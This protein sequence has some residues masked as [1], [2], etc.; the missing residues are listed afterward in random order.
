MTKV[1]EWFVVV[2]I[3]QLIQPRKWLCGNFGGQSFCWS[4]TRKNRS[5]SGSKPVRIGTVPLQSQ[6][7]ATCIASLIWPGPSTMPPPTDT[8]P[9]SISA[10]GW[11]CSGSDDVPVQAIIDS[12]L[13]EMAIVNVANPP[14]T[15]G[16]LVMD[17]VEPVSKPADGVYQEDTLYEFNMENPPRFNGPLAQLSLS[18]NDDASV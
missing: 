12:N 5:S 11:V 4:E 7:G 10:P 2:I 16:E 13:I 18:G 14:A 8:D 1:V 15:G 9:G 3:L 6:G 17:I